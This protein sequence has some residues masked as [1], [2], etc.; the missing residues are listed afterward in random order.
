MTAASGCAPPMPPRPA[1]QDPLALEV[2][3]IVL[4]A[5]LDE[6]LVGALHDALR[7]DIDPRAGRH[8]AVHHQALLIELVEM[9]PSSPNAARGWSWRSARAARRRW[10]RNTPT[11]LPD[12][13][14][15]V[16]SS[17][18][19]FSDATIGRNRSRCARRGRCRHRR[20]ARSGSRRRRD[21]DCSSASA[22]AL[23]SAR[24]CALSLVAA[25][26]ADFADVVT[27]IGH[28]VIPSGICGSCR[29]DAA[30]SGGDAFEFGED[31]AEMD[32]QPSRP[33]PAA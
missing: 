31:G 3:A 32:A 18:S 30:S 8:L 27:R 21:R 17:P 1:G 7:A 23:R 11:G 15:S 33:S 2:A 29:C 5:G 6:G 13:T 20:R 9:R 16:S 12:C 4:A 26:R 22:A 25:R 24:S 10:V 19:V 28:V 14:S